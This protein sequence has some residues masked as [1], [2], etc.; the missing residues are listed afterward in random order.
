MRRSSNLIL[1]I[2]TQGAMRW[3]SLLF[4]RSWSCWPVPS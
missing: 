2:K 1:M 3:T 4:Y